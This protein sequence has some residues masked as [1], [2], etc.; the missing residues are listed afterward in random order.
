M[1]YHLLHHCIN[2]AKECLIRSGFSNKSNGVVTLLIICFS[3]YFSFGVEK[4]VFERRSLHDFLSYRLLMKGAWF[5]LTQIF[6]QIRMLLNSNHL[7][8]SYNFD[9]EEYMEYMVTT[10]KN[11]ITPFQ[12]PVNYKVNTFWVFWVVLSSYIPNDIFVIID[13]GE[14]SHVL[15][16]WFNIKVTK[17]YQ[18]FMI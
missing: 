4:F 14:T 5:T 9:I 11:Q 18:V 7:K 13:Q 16:T 17:K 15:F 3:I 10:H 8:I 12:M 1:F 6:F 2:V